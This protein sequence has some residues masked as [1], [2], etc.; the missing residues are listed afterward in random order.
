MFALS[1]SV[2]NSLQITT[3]SSSHLCRWPVDARSRFNQEVVTLYLG[4]E[5]RMLY[6]QQAR[7]AR[8]IAAGADEGRAN[9]IGFKFSDFIIEIQFVIICRSRLLQR[10]DRV[11]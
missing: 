11:Q 10:L 1:E 7:G 4:I 2:Y 6:S 5:G 3:G 8:L 9:Q